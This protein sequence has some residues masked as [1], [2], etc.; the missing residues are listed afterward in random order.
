MVAVWPCFETVLP[1]EHLCEIMVINGSI[2]LTKVE[3]FFSTLTESTRLRKTR[4]SP[5][6]DSTTLLLSTPRTT[7]TKQSTLLEISLL[8]THYITLFPK[9]LL[10]HIPFIFEFRLL[11]SRSGLSAVHLSAFCS[12]WNACRVFWSCSHITSIKAWD[13]SSGSKSSQELK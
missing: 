8:Y 10:K 1:K 4:K 9:W 11:V 7:K 13:T 6:W 12:W 3:R 5:S 2:H